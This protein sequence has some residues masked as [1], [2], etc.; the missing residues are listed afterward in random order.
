LIKEKLPAGRITLRAWST[1]IAIS[2]SIPLGIRKAVQGW[3]SVLITWDV[4]RDYRGLCD[5]RFLFAIL[6]LVLFAGASFGRYSRCRAD[7]VTL[8]QL[9]PLGRSTVFISGTSRLPVLASNHLRP[10]RR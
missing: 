7:S 6:L 4:R 1:L 10:L 5:S 9:S 3:H 2:L 8:D